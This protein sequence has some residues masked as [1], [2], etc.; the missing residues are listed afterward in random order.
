MDLG[1]GDVHVDAAPSAKRS[2]M[3]TKK[4]LDE[5]LEA[6]EITKEQYD[7]AVAKLSDDAPS[8]EMCRQGEV[9]ELSVKS[10]DSEQPIWIQIAKP[11]KFRGHSAGHF[12]MNAAVFAQII[13]NFNARANKLIPVD[14]EHASEQHAAEGTIPHS[15]APAQGWITQLEQRADGNLWGLVE[16]LPLAKKYIKS[17]QYRYLS[18]A[19][20]FGAKDRV[21]GKP[22]GAYLSS[23]ALTNNPFLDG[24]QPVAAKNKPSVSVDTQVFTAMRDALQMPEYAVSPDYIL[25][26]LVAVEKDGFRD[27]H[28]IELRRALNLP[29]TMSTQDV[30]AAAKSACNE[31]LTPTILSPALPATPTEENK[32]AP[33]RN[34]RTTN[35]SVENKEKGELETQVS[36]LTL[37]LNAESAKIVTLTS[38]HEAAVK[39][40]TEENET[41]RKQIEVHSDR[42][43]TTL[44]DGA[45]SVYGEKMGLK[46]ESRPHLMRLAKNDREGFLALYPPV[47]AGQEHLGKTVA[48]GAHH[49]PP[50]KLPTSGGAEVVNLRDV[51]RDANVPSIDDLAVKLMSDARAQG[52]TMVR[53]E[54]YSRAHS[55]RTKLIAAAARKVVGGNGG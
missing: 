16:W 6:G 38:E 4:E 14:F 48:A 5:A 53:E 44:V 24:M 50:T 31:V 2:K 36:Q 9:V 20:V 28:A 18:P 26:M 52:I 33:A 41:L 27:K 45:L 23:V 40:L 8:T 29:L 43:L 3:K 12:E 13:A 15:G 32:P 7:A 46:A 51:A 35:M 11:G 10:A 34:E 54:A 21:S 1:Q 47:Q 22:I 49:V 30:F 25:P 17:K 37:K 19:I 55:E 42:E 39:K